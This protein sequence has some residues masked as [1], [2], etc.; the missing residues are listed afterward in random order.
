MSVSLLPSASVG[1]TVVPVGVPVVAGS[2]GGLVGAAVGRVCSDLARPVADLI[3][4]LRCGEVTAAAR[5]GWSLA[6]PVLSVLAGAAGGPE[7]VALLLGVRAVRAL[8][9]P[10]TPVEGQHPTQAPVTGPAW[11]ALQLGGMS[12]T[13]P[14]PPQH[15]SCSPAPCPSRPPVRTNPPCLHL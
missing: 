14:G 1:P 3:D 2:S 12:E 8:L 15:Q 10:A 6:E 9:C 5:H 7:G 11:G 13:P 4:A